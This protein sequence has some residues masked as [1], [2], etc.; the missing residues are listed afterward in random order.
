MIYDILVI[1]PVAV[2]VCLFCYSRGY[3]DGYRGRW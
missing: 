1:F 3:R 2:G